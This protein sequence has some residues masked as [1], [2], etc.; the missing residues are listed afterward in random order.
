MWSRRKDRYIGR[1]CSDTGSVS[2]GI[3]HIPEYRGVTGTPRGV[4]GPYWALV[5]ERRRRPRRGA[6]PKPNPNWEGGR[7]PFPS[8]LSPP[9]FLS[10]SYLEGGN[11]TPGGSRTPLGRA[12]ERA[13]PPLLHS[14]IYGGRGHPIDT[15]VDPRDRFLSRVRCP[16]P[17]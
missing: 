17:P 1:L 14:F 7:P 10:Y 11:P 16:F 5:G 3:G 8:S 9:S 4:Y 12:I 6:P 2:G 15:Q 13:G